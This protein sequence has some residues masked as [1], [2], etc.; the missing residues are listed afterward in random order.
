MTVQEIEGRGDQPEDTCKYER[1]SDRFSRGEADNQ[2]E[3]R[4]RETSAADPG[5]AHGESDEKTQNKVR[6]SV[7][8][9]KVWIP[10]SSFL[11]L[12]RPERG[13]AG[14]SGI[15][16]QGSQ[17]MLEYPRSYCGR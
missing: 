14:S 12:Q 4:D 5:E 7:F 2:K 10:H 16:V 8:S 3:R 17:P 1:G 6:H 11:P 15:A 9:E 13:F